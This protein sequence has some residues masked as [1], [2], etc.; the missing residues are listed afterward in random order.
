MLTVSK[1]LNALGMDA[2]PRGCQEVVTGACV[3][4][5]LATIGSLFVALPGENTDGH[6]Y[7]DQAF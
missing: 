1:V 5:R 6:L 4:S 2:D 7:V 3:D